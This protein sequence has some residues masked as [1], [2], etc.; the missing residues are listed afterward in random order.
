MLSEITFLAFSW[1]GPS[2][3]GLRLE[4]PTRPKSP[5]LKNPTRPKSPQKPFQ[6]GPAHGHFFRK[7]YSF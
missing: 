5:S 2:P 6:I 7:K 4:N 1:F 3:N